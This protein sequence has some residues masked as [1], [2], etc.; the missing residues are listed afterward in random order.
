MGLIRGSRLREDFRELGKH[1]GEFFQQTGNGFWLWLFDYW[2][3]ALS[4][5]NLLAWV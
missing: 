1:I 2:E 5:V 4:V 3:S